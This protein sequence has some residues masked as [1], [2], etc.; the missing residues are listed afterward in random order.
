[1]GRA[2]KAKRAKIAAARSVTLP[3]AEYYKLQ[4]LAQDVALA[5]HAAEK[6]VSAAN[7]RVRAVSE[8]R[9]AYMRELQKAHPEFDPFSLQYDSDDETLTLIP[10]APATKG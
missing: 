5:I 4:K 6:E 1:M 2:A 10:V 8:A 9:N 7:A 3:P